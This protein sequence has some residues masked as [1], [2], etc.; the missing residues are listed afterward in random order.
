VSILTKPYT[1]RLA[2]CFEPFQPGNAYD[3]VSQPVQSSRLKKTIDDFF[4]KSSTES[5]EKNLAVPPVGRVW[6]NREDRGSGA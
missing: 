1:Y 2:V 4:T 3:I 6:K 5:G